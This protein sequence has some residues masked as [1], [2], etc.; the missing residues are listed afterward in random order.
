MVSN[1]LATLETFLDLH[2]SKYEKVLIL[3]DFDVGV[4]EQHMQSFCETYTLKSLIKQSTCCKNPNS[5]MCIDLILTKIISSFQSTCVIE[6]K[7][8]DLITLTVRRKSFK[9]I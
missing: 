3:Q 4:N 8:F 6:N 9:Q 2:S 5:P 1:H 7:D